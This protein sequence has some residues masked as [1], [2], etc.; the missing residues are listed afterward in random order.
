MFFTFPRCFPLQYS[1]PYHGGLFQGHGA[2]C[3]INHNK[4]G[5]MKHMIC[6]VC[7]WA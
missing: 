6:L 3:G 7:P 4:E 2:S 5:S 1:I